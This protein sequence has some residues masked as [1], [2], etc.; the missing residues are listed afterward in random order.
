MHSIPSRTQLNGPAD[1][2]FECKLTVDGESYQVDVHS[3]PDGAIG[4]DV[5][6]GRPLF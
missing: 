2:R 6:L 5:I 4:Y 3:V 1:R